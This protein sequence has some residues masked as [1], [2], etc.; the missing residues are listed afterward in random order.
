MLVGVDIDERK[1]NELRLQQSYEELEATYEE[2][3]ATEVELQEQF[4]VAGR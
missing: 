2:L 4:A 1:Q 3:S